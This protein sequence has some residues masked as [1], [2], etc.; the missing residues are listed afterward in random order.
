MDASD[1]VLR[2]PLAPCKMLI[3]TAQILVEDGGLTSLSKYIG[4]YP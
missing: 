1:L 3:W 2:G 4:S